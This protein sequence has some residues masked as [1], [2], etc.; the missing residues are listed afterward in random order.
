MG[1]TPKGLTLNPFHNKTRQTS[2]DVW[3][4]LG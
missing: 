2:H 3:R 4:V 1:D